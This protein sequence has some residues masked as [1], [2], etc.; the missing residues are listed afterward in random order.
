MHFLESDESPGNN[1]FDASIK[2]PLVKTNMLVG[3]EM[4][5]LEKCYDN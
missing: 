5:L 3:A 4:L 2:N 1:V